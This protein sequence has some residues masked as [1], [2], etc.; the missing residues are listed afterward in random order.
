[1]KIRHLLF[2]FLVVP[3]LVGG[4]P[5]RNPN[6]T[7]RQPGKTIVIISADR[8]NFQ[9]LGSGRK[10]VSLGGNAVVQQEKTIF[11]A[12]SIV[13]DQQLNT[14]DATGNIH[15]NDADSVQVYSQHL[16]YQGKE[17]KRSWTN[18]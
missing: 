10:T 2:A 17:K 7:A 8:Y 4:Q 12:D 3:F 13:L 5:V 9:D 18:K 14:L 11:A 1:M 16:L 6:A 15:I